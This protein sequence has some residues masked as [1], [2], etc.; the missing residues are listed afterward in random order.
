MLLVRILLFI[1]RVVVYF[2][3]RLSKRIFKTELPPNFYLTGNYG[4]VHDEREKEDVELVQGEI[5]KDL[6]GMFI[7]N[8]PNPQFTPEFYHWFAGDG[9]LHGVH[10]NAGKATYTNKFVKTLKYLAEKAAG[11]EVFASLGAMASDPTHFYKMMWSLIKSKG[12]MDTDATNTANTAL[13]YHGRRF[14]AL[15]EAARPVQVNAGN[16]DSIGTYTFDGK[17]K[18]NVTAHPKVDPV[19]G[20]MVF[21]GYPVGPGPV[22]V[23]YSVATK[24]GDIPTS[25]EIDCGPI[26]KMMHDFAVTE[27]YSIIM[28]LPFLIDP[29]RMILG[30]NPFNFDA[31]MSSRF[32]VF[33]R[34]AK[35]QLEIKWFTTKSCYIFHTGNAWEENDEVVMIA[36]RSDATSSLGLSEQDGRNRPYLFEFRFN[37]KTGAMTETQISDVSSEFPVINE[38]LLGRKSRFVWTAYFPSDRPQDGRAIGLVKKDLKTGDSITVTHPLNAFGGEFVFVPRDGAVE[39]DDGFMTGF[40][41]DENAN[42]SYLSIRAARDLKEIALVKMPR[43]VPYGFHGRW[44]SQE[45]IDQQILAL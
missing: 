41:H 30:E 38:S 9:M 36:C 2:A 29:R 24:D 42:T 18:H 10:F 31:K 13:I 32:G 34:H 6:R 14:L 35:S 28:D 11:K 27:H 20:E 37:M 4:P 21:F 8:G 44:V 1:I 45:Q 5:P 17:L 40:V 33:P 16:L 26:A 25:M 43:R 12:K 22:T 39:E 15:M 19:T 7:R 23:K 3:L